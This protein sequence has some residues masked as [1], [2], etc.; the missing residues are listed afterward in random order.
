VRPLEVVQAAYRAWEA[1]PATAVDYFH[2]D[3]IADTSA[4]LPDGRVYRGR[5][6]VERGWVTWR[7]A[8]ERYEVD[9]EGF[10]EDGDKVV[11]LT[12]VRAVSKGHGIE[13]DTRGADVWTVRDDLIVGLAIYLDRRKLES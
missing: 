11:A 12:R 13:I 5:A 4:A 6:E 2:P 9:I 1:D 7:G 10:E 8:W 3:V